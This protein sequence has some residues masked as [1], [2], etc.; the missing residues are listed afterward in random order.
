MF[1]YVCRECIKESL[2][3]SKACPTCKCEVTRRDVE[4][5]EVINGFVSHMKV[6]DG[7]KDSLVPAMKA[8]EAPGDERGREEIDKLMLPWVQGVQDDEYNS[9]SES[10]SGSALEQ[11]RNRKSS[12]SPSPCSPGTRTG[13]D[14]DVLVQPTQHA[15]AVMCQDISQDKDTPLPSGQRS[16]KDFISKT[17]KDCSQTPGSGF[18]LKKAGK[19]HVDDILAGL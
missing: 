7:L 10:F 15:P 8:L 9:P 1:L 11:L 6:L 14:D 12:R 3:H 18:A 17:K 4:T 19:R 2:K 16:M 13:G 5:D